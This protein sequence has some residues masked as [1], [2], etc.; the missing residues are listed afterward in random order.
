MTHMFFF[1]VSLSIRRKFSLAKFTTCQPQQ[2]E[3]Y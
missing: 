2:T 3:T 1:A